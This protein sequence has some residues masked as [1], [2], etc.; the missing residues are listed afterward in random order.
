MAL[1]YMVLLVVAS[2]ILKSELHLMRG[3]TLIR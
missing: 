3:D 1:M 2:I